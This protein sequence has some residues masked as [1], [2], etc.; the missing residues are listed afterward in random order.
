MSE[1][2][3]FL[4]FVLAIDQGTSSTKTIIFDNEGNAVA[5]GHVDLHTNYFDNGL[6]EQDAEDI[7][8]NV[9][10]SVS[11]CLIDFKNKGHDV[12]D[13]ASCGISNQR[14]TFVLWDKSGVALTPAVVWACK[15]STGICKKLIEKG[16]N[17]FINTRTGLIIDPYFSATKLLW[18]LENDVSLKEK[19][20]KGEVYFGTIDCW[21]LFKM[22]NGKSYKTDYTN[23]HRT[24]LFNIHTLSWDQEILKLWGLEKLNL[25]EVC[26]SSSEFGVWN[27][28]L[29]ANEYSKFRIPNSPLP[30]HAMIG[31]SHA[32]AF[33][34]GCFEAG[35][36][37]VTLGTGSSIMMNT[38]SKPVNSKHGMLSTI[39]WST[40]NRVD[41]ALEGAIVSCGS[42][43]EWLKNSLNLF[44]DVTETE[45]MATEI[46]DNAGVYLIPSFSGLGAPHWQMN[47]KASIE[48]MTFGTT[49]NHIVRAALESIPYQI[50]DVVTA[51]END[52]NTP[53]KFISVNG[54]LTKNQ[55]VLQ[56]LVDLLGIELKKQQNPDVS[57]L[58]AAYLSGLQ[59]GIYDNIEQ[60]KKLNQ[61][62]TQKILPNHSNEIVKIG[63]EGWKTKIQSIQI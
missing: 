57:A 58:G 15:R 17:D 40:E 6:V 39:C 33:G 4:K 21:L 55:F 20:E 45:K 8:E 28:E 27:W 23:A 41:F 19:V 44:E 2:P 62:K 31:D 29:I 52:M 60:L 13:I 5:K 12:N 53:L 10:D 18:L 61:S 51:M 38:G 35:T 24:L 30:I 46:P 63:Y 32:A 43:I 56:F 25:P 47:R 14:E 37:K 48:G 3:S 34:E 7:Y 22:T 59:S 26:P 1:S 54:G 50:K 11:V 42:T 9:I 36:A 16:Q 49:K